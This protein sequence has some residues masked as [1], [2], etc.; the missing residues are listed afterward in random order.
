[1][2]G[3]PL[4][5]AQFAH[6]AHVNFYGIPEEKV[7]ALISTPVGKQQIGNFIFHFAETVDGANK[8]HVA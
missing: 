6:P 1:M 3:G 8:D 5:P 4:A 7:S 2:R